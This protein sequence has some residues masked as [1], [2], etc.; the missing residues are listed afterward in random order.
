MLEDGARQRPEGGEGHCLLA[1]HGGLGVLHAHPLL[2]TT[3]SRSACSTPLHIDRHGRAAW[4]F[5]HKLA[6]EWA[7][8]PKARFELMAEEALPKARV[9]RARPGPSTGGEKPPQMAD[10]HA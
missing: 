10:L 2:R 5:K 6:E 7:E 4:G 1:L 9:K 3:A 8:L